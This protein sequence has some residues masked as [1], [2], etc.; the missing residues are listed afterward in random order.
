MVVFA[1]RLKTDAGKENQD[2][3]ARPFGRKAFES[4]VLTCV[5]LAENAYFH[6]AVQV[7]P[8][9]SCC[10]TSLTVDGLA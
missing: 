10:F 5:F 8:R 3:I 4:V 2:S 7:F 6:E 1:F 9:S